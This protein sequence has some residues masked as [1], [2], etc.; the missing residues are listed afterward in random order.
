MYKYR[1][2]KIE[3]KLEPFYQNL[4]QAKIIKEYLNS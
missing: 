4:L 1:P 2:H 3:F